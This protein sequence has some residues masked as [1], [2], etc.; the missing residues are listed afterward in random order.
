MLDVAAVAERLI[1]P[2]PFGPRLRDA[3]IVLAG[4]H[5]LGKISDSF[6]A[7]L[8]ENVPQP[9][10]RQ[11]EL[12]E[13]LFYAEDA[14]FE[15]RLG[16]TSRVRQLL[17][18]A[19]AG[20]HGRPP[21]RNFGGLPA[22]ARP[23]RELAGALRCVGEGREAARLLLDEFFNLW[24]EASLEGLTLLEASN[25][26][27][28]LPGFCTAA[29]WVASNPCWFKPQAE[30]ASFG[31]Y[32][33]N[34]RIVASHAVAEAGISGVPARDVQLFDFTL[35][36]MQAA[37]AEI[38]LPDGPMLAVV[39]DETGA[40]KTEAALFLAHRMVLAGKGRGLF[41]ALPTMAT[42]DAMFIRASAIVGRMLDSPSVTL[43]HG[44]AGLSVPF[45][46]LV[47][48]SRT[49]GRE[50]I[51][52]SDWLAESSRRA[53]L[54]DVG[55][56]TIDQALLCVLP[57]RFQTLRYYGLSSKILIVDEVH[58]MGE[59]YIAEE[60]VALLRVCPRS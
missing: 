54:A 56:G 7:M 45:R 52:S 59:P 33:Q 2:F 18:A 27:W 55:V 17:Y 8:R 35:R 53:L 15:A 36:P 42:A 24:P 1:A 48:G 21:V 4:L 10:F 44:R 11:W 19:V 25:L 16:G 34:A 6:R 38:A 23:P 3:L 57:V 5:D 49:G 41:F 58:E 22:S 43:A 47:Q 39:E 13:A 12:S 28:W 60:L 32:L 46:D 40:G 30:A 31:T 50:E 14:R 26:S 20:H 37:C 29:D 9:G 51:T